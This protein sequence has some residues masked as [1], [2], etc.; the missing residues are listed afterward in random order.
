MVRN[1]H[2]HPETEAHAASLERRRQAGHAADILRDEDG[3]GEDL[4]RNHTRQGQVLHGRLIDSLVEIIVVAGEGLL[5]P[6]VPIEHAGHAVET[7]AVQLILLHPELAVAQQ[8]IPRLV[9]AVVET[10]GI[11]GRMMALRTVVEIQVLPAIEVAQSLGLVLDHMAVD[12]VHDHRDAQPVGRIDQGLEFLGRA[13]TGTQGIEIRYLI[14]EGT[15]VRMLLQGHDLD[16][17]VAELG[18]MG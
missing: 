14:A 9:F 5:Q 2:R 17:I 18:D 16:G 12:Q 13:E 11:P 10:A 3:A 7:E 1:A 4:P 6:V 15:V 8:E